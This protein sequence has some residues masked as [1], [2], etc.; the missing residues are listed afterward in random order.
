MFELGQMVQ[1]YQECVE[2][3]QRLSESG[4]LFKRSVLKDDSLLEFVPVNLHMQE[5]KVSEGE[6]HK[7]MRMQ[8]ISDV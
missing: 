1:H 6:H 8:M 4:T 7:G 5:M 3:L 2:R